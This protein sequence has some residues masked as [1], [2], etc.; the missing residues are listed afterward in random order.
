MADICEI[1]I[2]Q[3]EFWEEGAHIDYESFVLCSKCN[4]EVELLQ[5]ESEGEKDFEKCVE[6]V[7]K[8]KTKNEK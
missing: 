7:R 3:I 6:E 2:K 5:E 1:C 8:R 4:E